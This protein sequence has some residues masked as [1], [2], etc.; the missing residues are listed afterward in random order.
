[1]FVPGSQVKNCGFPIAVSSE[2]FGRKIKSA[3]LVE[4]HKTER[5]I[6]FVGHPEPVGTGLRNHE[7]RHGEKHEVVVLRNTN[8]G[9]SEFRIV[10]DVKVFGRPNALPVV[11]AGNHGVDVVDNG[12]GLPAVV[13]TAKKSIGIT[14]GSGGPLVPTGN[15]VTA[16]LNRIQ[17][18]RW[19]THRARGTGS[20]RTVGC[21]DLGCCV[22]VDKTGVGRMIGGRRGIGLFVQYRLAHV[23]DSGKA[24]CPNRTVVSVGFDRSGGW[25]PPCQ[26]Q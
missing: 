10:I 14:S 11:R 15:R 21:N 1:M 20:L 17:R 18:T 4:I 7:G 9:V 6:I 3:V 12:I 23:I 2:L 25:V 26:G 8:P 16:F 24:I 13:S 19:R 22:T 5:T